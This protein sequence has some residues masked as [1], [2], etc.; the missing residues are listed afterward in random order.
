MCGGPAWKRE[1]VPDH[2]VCTHRLDTCLISDDIHPPIVR[3]CRYPGVHRQWFHDANEVRIASSLRL[4]YHRLS[5]RYL[6][7]YILVLKSFLV[8]VSDIFTA[9]TMLTTKTW[10]NQIFQNCKQL[11][12]CVAIPFV[13]G[14]WLF[15][16][17][18]I[19]SFVLVRHYVIFSPWSIH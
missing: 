8:Y 11:S 6:W 16:G 15:V 5:Y 12:G 19:F 17:C 4:C 3:F 9:M 10:S 18:I 14:K 2:K 13:I 1:I 7:V